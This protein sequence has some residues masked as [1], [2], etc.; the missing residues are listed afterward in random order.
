MSNDI[1]VDDR[2]DA[3]YSDL[4]SVDLQPLWTQAR[5]L[6]P[7]TPKPD[8]LPWLWQGETFARSPHERATSSR[9]SVAANGGCSRCRT[10][11]SAGAVHDLDVVG[12]DPGPRCARERARASAQ[13]VRDQVRAR[14]QRS[15]DDG[16]RRR[17]RHA[18]GRPRAHPRLD[19][20]RPQQRRRR[21]D[22]LVRRARP[23]D[24]GRRSRRSSSRTIPI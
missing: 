17:V 1:G 3:F 8:A 10:Q 24:H 22:D 18:S 23:A 4:G 19:L 6:L 12:R 16:R 7:A 20:P 9:S 13:R 2:L 5:N 11:V 15:V 14:G 21:A